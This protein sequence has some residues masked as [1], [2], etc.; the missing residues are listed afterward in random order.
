MDHL[1]MYVLT[2]SHVLRLW[3]VL[4]LDKSLSVHSSLVDIN[5]FVLYVLY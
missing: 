1:W 5:E 4:V 2:L 3:A